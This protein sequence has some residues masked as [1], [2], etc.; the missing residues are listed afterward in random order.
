MKFIQVVIA[1]VA[2]VAASASMNRKKTASHKRAN[3]K[4][5]EKCTKGVD[6]CQYSSCCEGKTNS[7][8]KCRSANQ[9]K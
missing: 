3:K 2:I 6:T 1:L 7:D 5:G 9:C 8:F 4:L